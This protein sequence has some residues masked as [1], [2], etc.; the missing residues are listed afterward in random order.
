MAK[1]KMYEYG[2]GV[3]ALSNTNINK[4]RES[5]STET[6]KYKTKMRD[7]LAERLSQTNASLKAREEVPSVPK[8]N[9]FLFEE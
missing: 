7:D 6:A 4:S 5:V 3:S 9:K 1:F 8:W 2:E